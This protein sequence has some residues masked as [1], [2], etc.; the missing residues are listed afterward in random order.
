[1]TDCNEGSLQAARAVAADMSILLN[2][3]D[4]VDVID[5][6]ASLETQKGIINWGAGPRILVSTPAYL[7]KSLD[8]WRIGPML[9]LRLHSRSVARAS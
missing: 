9:W 3:F 5:V 8:P 4:V 1:M 6:Q 2:A 7:K